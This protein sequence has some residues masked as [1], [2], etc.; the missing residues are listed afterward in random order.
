MRFSIWLVRIAPPALLVVVSAVC[1]GW[2]WEN[3]P[4]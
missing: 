2:K 3:F 1:A 4:H